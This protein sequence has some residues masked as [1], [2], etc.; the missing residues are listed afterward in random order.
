MIC[1]HLLFT[2]LT[3]IF[4][5]LKW[6]ADTLLCKASLILQEAKPALFIKAEGNRSHEA[7]ECYFRNHI[8][9][10]PYSIGQSKTLGWPR[11]KK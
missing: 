8:S 9:F 4:G 1:V 2:G 7:S 3:L 10:L 11:F 5:G 6:M